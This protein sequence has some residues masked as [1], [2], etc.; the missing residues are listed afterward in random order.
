[1]SA[2][3]LPPAN[4]GFRECADIE[5]ASVGFAVK[6]GAR[7]RGLGRH[8]A[9]GEAPDICR[10]ATGVEIDALDHTGVN[11][12]GAEPYVIKVR[13]LDAVEEISDVAGW[14][15][16]YVKERDPRHNRGHAGEHFNGAERVTESPRELTHL[17]AV[18]RDHPG[19]LA[20]PGHG[21]FDGTNL[22]GSL[23]SALGWGRPATAAGSSVGIG[24]GLLKTHFEPN[25]SGHR[26]SGATR[27]F[28][29]PPQGS[30][31]RGHCE[32]LVVI[33][34]FRGG[35]A[36][37]FGDGQRENDHGFALGPFRISYL[38]TRA[39]DGRHQFGLRGAGRGRCCRW[40]RCAG[41]GRCRGRRHRIRMSGSARDDGREKGDPDGQVPASATNCTG[42]L[43]VI[44]DDGGERKSRRASA[45]SL[46]IRWPAPSDATPC[47]FQG[48]GRCTRLVPGPPL[49][50]WWP[51]RY[52]RS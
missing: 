7:R 34:R 40:G 18:E 5:D 52:R 10:V 31:L 42:R 25:T 51:S 21:D 12:R 19:W 45:T 2:E 41:R 24:K 32:G 39:E 26:L 1:M 23:R 20:F 36:P 27:R 35:H 4:P 47:G 28:E 48:P 22:F 8:D 30:V 13:D 14:C 11:D 38:R 6:I 43:H 37:I 33:A 17:G 9:T 50:A 46:G 16:A 15:P 44:G 49:G 29:G 3:P